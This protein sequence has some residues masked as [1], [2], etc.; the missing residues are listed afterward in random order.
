[1]NGM[2]R[3]RDVLRGREFIS[4]EIAQ[5]RFGL[6]NEEAGAWMAAI[7]TMRRRWQHIL[8]TPQDTAVGGEWLGVYTKNNAHVPSTIFQAKKNF[9]PRLGLGKH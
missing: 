3:Y 5:G 9:E 4:V 6:L 2:H 7:R 8:T 1:M